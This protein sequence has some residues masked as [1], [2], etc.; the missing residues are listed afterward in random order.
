VL[1]KKDL[2]RPYSTGHF[3]TQYCDK[4]ISNMFLLTNQ[5]KLFK[6]H[7]LINLFVKCLPWPFDI[8]GSKISFYRNIVRQMSRVN[9]A[10]R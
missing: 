8:H 7:A 9:K 2:L 5:G 1:R 4:N 6:K 10:L 3:S